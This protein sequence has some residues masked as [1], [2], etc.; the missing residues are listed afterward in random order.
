VPR[1]T[2]TLAAAPV[3]RSGVIGRDVDGEGVLFDTDTAAMFVLNDTAT[4]LWQCLDGTVTLAEL[5]ADVAETFGIDRT[6]A[7]R[8]VLRLAQDL[9]DRGLLGG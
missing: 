2:L 7:E 6:T 3:F 1:L 5:A 4:L 8:D 9:A